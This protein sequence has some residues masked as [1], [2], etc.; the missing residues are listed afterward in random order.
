MPHPCA[1]GPTPL[2][3][4]LLNTS[5]D[6][7]LPPCTVH[8]MPK[9]TLWGSLQGKTKRA[10]AA[11]AEGEANAAGS[12]GGAGSN[13]LLLLLVVAAATAAL[14]AA[15]HRK[16]RQQQL[17]SA[18]LIGGLVRQRRRGADPLPSD[19]GIELLAVQSDSRAEHLR[20]RRP[21]AQEL[22]PGRARLKAMAQWQLGGS[23]ARSGW[24]EARLLSMGAL[25]K[26]LAHR[27]EESSSSDD[28]REDG[29]GS[30]GGSQAVVR[31]VRQWGLPTDSLRMDA[32]DLQVGQCPHGSRQCSRVTGRCGCS[33]S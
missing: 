16:K 12:G 25:P 26:A 28:N 30:Q 31:L 15:A 2:C 19:E 32:T 1:R 33:A 17:E 4:D 13:L 22:V 14:A 10:R 27:L 20:H 7:T 29:S 8:D 6:P 23:A 3:R 21:Q 9:L 5:T 18:R 11:A 24:R